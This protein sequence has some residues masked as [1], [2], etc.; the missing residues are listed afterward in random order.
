MQESMIPSCSST[1]HVV[2]IYKKKGS[3][4]APE[5][6][7]PISL[8]CAT[9]KVMERIVKIKMLDHLVNQNILTDNQHG[10]LRKRSTL[11]QLLVCLN[12]WTEIIDNGDCVDVVYLDFAKAFDTVSHE[13]LIFKLIMYKFDR[14]V[15]EWIKAFLSNRCQQTKVESSYSPMG[16]VSSGIPQGSVLGPI[17]FLIYINDITSIVK[18]SYVKLFA[19]DSKLYIRVSSTDDCQLLQD[20]LPQGIPVD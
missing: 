1:A 3:M 14:K 17:L 18:N 4:S 13:K 8:T 16:P 5:N 20:D 15:I 7:R 6:Y 10:F 9:S 11:T 19:D 12:D 2:P